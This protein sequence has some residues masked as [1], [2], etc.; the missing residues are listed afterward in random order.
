MEEVVKLDE[1]GKEDHFHN[2]RSTCCEYLMNTCSSASR[3]E[4]CNVLRRNL[5]VQ[6]VRY[7]KSLLDPQRKMD[8]KSKVNKRFLSE[9]EREEK[10]NDQKRRRRNADRRAEYW[11]CKASE[12]KK[13]R[14]IAQDDEHDLMVM[15]NELDNSSSGPEDM[16][17]D[18]PKMSMFWEMQREV[19]S[20]NNHKTAIKWHHQ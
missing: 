1:T 18:N 11:K 4:G 15:F 16:F 7:N 9:E 13:M 10:E 17:P 19:I 8:S 12:E 3:C 6:L 20:K 14:H 5:S 2:R